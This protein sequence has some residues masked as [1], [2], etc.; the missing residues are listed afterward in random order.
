MEIMEMYLSALIPKC[1]TEAIFIFDGGIR[2]IWEKTSKG[3]KENNK[4]RI[5]I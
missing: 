3:F 2:W 4:N 1:W 5:Q